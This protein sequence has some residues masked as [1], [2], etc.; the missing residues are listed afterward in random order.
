[1]N[2][3]CKDCGYVDPLWVE[4]YGDEPHDPPNVHAPGWPQGLGEPGYGPD[5]TGSGATGVSNWDTDYDGE[6]CNGSP[7]GREPSG[8]VT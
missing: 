5:G 8:E 6:W 4:W 1:M 7:R 3:Q 2:G